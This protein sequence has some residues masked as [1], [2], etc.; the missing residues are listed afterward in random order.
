M[1]VMVMVL[2]LIGIGVTLYVGSCI[3]LLVLV[4]KLILCPSSCVSLCQ[5]Y[6]IGQY[7]M[8][9]QEHHEDQTVEYSMVVQNDKGI[10]AQ[11]STRYDPGL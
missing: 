1:S 2:L 10:K 5:T 3:P 9:V 11:D 8:E 4:V 6:D 7:V